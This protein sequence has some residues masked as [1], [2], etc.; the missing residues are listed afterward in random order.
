MKSWISNPTDTTSGENI[1]AHCTLPR[2]LDGTGTHWACLSCAFRVLTDTQ[3]LCATQLEA[4]KIVTALWMHWSNKETWNALCGSQDFCHALAS[5]CL[6]ALSRRPTMLTNE[7]LDCLLET[8]RHLCNNKEANPV[9][10]LLVLSTVVKHGMACDQVFLG[11]FITAIHALLECAQEI[12]ERN[13]NTPWCQTFRCNFALFEEFLT[14]ALQHCPSGLL[15][16][17]TQNNRDES[18]WFVAET[19]AV[20]AIIRL[21]THLNG[22]QA[23]IVRPCSA[24]INS[25]IDRAIQTGDDD[26]ILGATLE[27]V[28][29]VSSEFERSEKALPLIKASLA[30]QDQTVQMKGAAALDSLLHKTQDLSPQVH[31]MHI[32]QQLVEVLWSFLPQSPEFSGFLTTS[33]SIIQV[34]WKNELS[35]ER[36][37]DDTLNLKGLLHRTL[38]Q[39]LFSQ[40][41]VQQNKLLNNTLDLIEMILWSSREGD[42]VSKPLARSVS[43][44]LHTACQRVQEMDLPLCLICHL[45]RILRNEE[46]CDKTCLMEIEQSVAQRLSIQPQDCNT[47]QETLEVIAHSVTPLTVTETYQNHAMTCFKK[48]RV[49][50]AIAWFSALSFCSDSAINELTPRILSTSILWGLT[51]SDA[52]QSNQELQNAAQHFLS[53]VITKH[54]STCVVTPS[55][56]SQVTLQCLTCTR[57][58]LTAQQRRTLAAL[59]VAVVN[60]AT[61]GP[62]ITALINNLARRCTTREETHLCPSDICFFACLGVDRAII[63][64]TVFN[65]CLLSNAPHE[66]WFD[67]CV[68][69]PPPALLLNRICFEGGITGLFEEPFKHWASFLSAGVGTDELIEWAS[70]LTTPSLVFVFAALSNQLS[71]DGI[72]Q[73]RQTLLRLMHI[74]IRKSEE[75][76]QLPAQI[77]LEQVPQWF[78]GLQEECTMLQ[79]LLQ[80]SQ[81]LSLHACQ[82]L[83]EQLCKCDQMTPQKMS[84]LALVL[85]G[86]RR[87]YPDIFLS[88]KKRASCHFIPLFGD[89]CSDKKEYLN[90]A[91]AALGV[92]CIGEEC[93]PE[94]PSVETIDDI[95]SLSFKHRNYSA[96]TCCIQSLKMKLISVPELTEQLKQRTQL[97]LVHGLFAP[98]ENCQMVAADTA[99][100]LGDK[101][102]C[103]ANAWNISFFDSFV[104][105]A[106]GRI[107]PTK[108]WIVYMVSFFSEQ[109]RPLWLA[110]MPLPASFV[111]ALLEMVRTAVAFGKID[112]STVL[113]CVLL[114]YIRSCFPQAVTKEAVD[115]LATNVREI[116]SPT[117]QRLL[118]PALNHTD[119]STLT[120]LSSMDTDYVVPAVPCFLQAYDPYSLLSFLQHALTTV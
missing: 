30:S 47:A 42:R 16:K 74:L 98:D 89:V 23:W 27:L 82:F 81:G 84:C 97:L 90:T 115:V 94:L 85:D 108:G 96:A 67:F 48:H 58:T 11:R 37:C 106:L 76:Q 2:V 39:T 57:P 116:L 6:T 86:A 26:V 119:P 46:N 64:S 22:S 9:C 31:T 72:T 4:A 35:R 14:E 51:I 53:S 87:N 28:S 80:H 114:F 113:L 92:L 118:F 1:H 45:H 91:I 73:K 20:Q 66:E 15:I 21:L 52:P 111:E 12:I 10:A 60:G 19:D 33:F 34:L 105:M 112:E 56:N 8:F 24:T 3:E 32:D 79:M 54:P 43:E 5:A 17:D 103:S 101:V 36:L 29:S 68:I 55:G 63:E 65:T 102:S 99:V 69:T 40:V 71:Q 110:S 100:F 62:H 104:S 93:S 75:T 38:H 61:L 7:V 117:N 95:L 13:S 77:V 70:K 107:T 50:C 44:V 109:T 120:C 25:A 88:L 49:H 59:F 18:S 83:T 41:D 78:Q